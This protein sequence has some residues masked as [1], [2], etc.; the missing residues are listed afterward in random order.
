MLNTRT[1]STS[2]LVSA[3]MT[4]FIITVMAIRY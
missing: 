1:K 4:F 3:V 2:I